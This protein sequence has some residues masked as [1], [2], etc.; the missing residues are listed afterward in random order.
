MRFPG[1]KR[2]HSLRSC[3]GFKVGIACRR[4]VFTNSRVLRGLALLLVTPFVALHAQTRWVGSW[5]AAQQLPEPR[6]ALAADDLRDATLRQIVHL[7]IGGPEIRVR[8]SNR[9]GHAP[10]ELKSVH[11]SKPVS[12]AS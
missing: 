4:M 10:L 11:I 3:A 2:S 9:F 1:R 7:S 6:N 8:V 12:A 5:A